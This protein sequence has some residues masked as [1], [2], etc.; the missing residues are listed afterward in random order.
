MLN[1][2]A[3]F[4]VFAVILLLS[5]AHTA[6]AWPPDEGCGDCQKWDGSANGGAGDCVDD[7]SNDGGCVAECHTGS[8]SGGSC[9][10]NPNACSDGCSECNDDGEC[11]STCEEGDSCC[12]DVC[13]DPNT[14]DCCEE[15]I[16]DP[17]TEDCCEAGIFDPITEECCGVNVVLICDPNAC[18]DCNDIAG[19]CELICTAPTSACDGKGSCVGCISDSDCKDPNLPACNLDTQECVPCFEYDFDDGKGNPYCSGNS[20]GSYCDE[21]IMDCN[22]CDDPTFFAPLVQVIYGGRVRSFRPIYIHP[23]P[24]NAG[25]I[26]TQYRPGV[27]CWDGHVTSAGNEYNHADSPG[28]FDFNQDIDGDGV[29]DLITPG[30]SDNLWDLAY[31]SSGPMPTANRISGSTASCSSNCY[32]Y[33]TTGSGWINGIS[34]ILADD[35][36]V[37]NEADAEIII[38]GDHVIKVTQHDTGGNIIKTLEKTRESAIYE[39]E[40]TSSSQY[41][42]G[43]TFYKQNP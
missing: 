21:H 28:G 1:R 5:L 2:K 42:R 22:T 20:S 34:T 13:Y 25:F 14:E 7:D 27:T 40:Y 30:H 31:S 41:N 24:N 38:V 17:N 29:K 11:E 19:A 37:C 39:I 43:G 6:L 3:I 32:G 18:R 23:D 36:Q 26:D 12:G 10:V 16:Y 4:L 35:Y 15:I 33:A 9:E 8:C